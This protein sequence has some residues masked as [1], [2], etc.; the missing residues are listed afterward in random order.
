METAVCSSCPCMFSRPDSCSITWWI[1]K[2]NYCH[3][4]LTQSKMKIK[5][6][7]KKSRKVEIVFSVKICDEKCRGSSQPLAERVLLL[8]VL[9]KL[10]EWDRK[11]NV[12]DLCAP[13]Y[14][15]AFLQN[16][17][18]TVHLSRQASPSAKQEMYLWECKWDT[19]TSCCVIMLLCT[20]PNT[21]MDAE[22]TEITFI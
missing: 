13:G 1:R 8:N 21:I 16:V 3:V 11:N 5:S 4:C 10:H 19:G 6:R 18:T 20:S 17:T 14:S 2:N 22:I 9:A 15:V 7:G 12:F